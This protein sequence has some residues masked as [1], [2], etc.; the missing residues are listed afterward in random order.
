MIFILAIPFFE[1]ENQSQKLDP[2]FQI[3]LDIY[4]LH[5]SHHISQ[6]TARSLNEPT[7][8]KN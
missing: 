7:R 5:I 3:N 8:I 1:L 6:L 2:P 4:C